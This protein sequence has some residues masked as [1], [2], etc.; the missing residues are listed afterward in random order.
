MGVLTFV[1]HASQIRLRPTI[2]TNVCTRRRRILPRTHNQVSV[3]LLIQPRA[4]LSL[5]ASSWAVW[6]TLLGAAV[7]G[8]AAN[9]TKLGAALSPPIVTTLTTMLLSNAGVLPSSHIAYGIATK[10]LVPFAIPCLLFN[11]DLFRVV[12]DTGRLFPAFILGTI[13]TVVSIVVAYHLVPLAPTFG[14]SE[15]WK[16][17]AAL[18]ARHIGGAVNFVSAADS[19]NISPSG[20]TTTLAADN[21]VLSAYFV[22][23]FFLA[24]RVNDPAVDRANAAD[25]VGESATYRDVDGL[26]SLDTGSDDVTQ[27]K[28][29]K[30]TQ[31]R[32]ASSSDGID[33]AAEDNETSAERAKISVEEIGAAL[34]VSAFVCAIGT[35]VSAYMPQALGVI[36]TITLISLALST[37]FAGTLGRLGRAGNS[38]G[39]MFMQLFFAA[40]GASGSIVSVVKSAPI[41]FVFI[42]VHL[43]VH[44]CILMGLGRAMQL[45]RAELLVASNAN[46]G[47]PATALAMA[48]AKNWRSLLIP[49][50]LI[51][52]FGYSVATFIGLGVG[53][54]ILKR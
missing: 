38:V 44:L 23:L 28:F 15:G 41:L 36:P 50:L 4:T 25:V 22:L 9:R 1:S 35:W 19:L 5:P 14:V 47:G 48:A 13:G 17:A 6:A 7:G 33:T 54:M 51:G 49:S 8:L 34:T 21:V 53:H 29:T 10:I 3:P 16:I 45:H 20:V 11:A 30:G 24:R 39:L 2:G 43:V 27:D 18:C 31:L 42:G 40:C 52:V 26:K 12:R 46:V 32:Q 37:M